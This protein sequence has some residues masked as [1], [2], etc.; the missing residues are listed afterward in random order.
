MVMLYINILESFNGIFLL[1]KKYIYSSMGLQHN[2]RCIQVERKTF[3]TN[4]Q[5]ICIL[6][7]P[8]RSVLLLLETSRKA[9]VIITSLNENK[10]CS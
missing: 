2:L 7:L 10:W 9:L 5:N 1:M 3:N 8:G 4:Q 6:I